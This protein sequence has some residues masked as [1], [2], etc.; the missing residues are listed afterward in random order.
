[1]TIRDFASTLA[2]RAFSGPV[3]DA[4]AQRGDILRLSERANEAVIA[5][6]DPGRLDGVIRLALATRMARLVRADAAAASYRDR[7]MAVRPSARML[8]IADGA[9]PDDAFLSLIVAYADLV[10]QT[11]RLATRKHVVTLQKAGMTD[12]EI[13]QLAELIACVNY[14]TRLGLGLAAL[15]E[16]Q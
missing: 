7:L 13:V 12:T 5:P 16:T 2:G 6:R 10:T 3:A 1:M 15:Q 8:A 14:Q 9:P 4:L 11:P